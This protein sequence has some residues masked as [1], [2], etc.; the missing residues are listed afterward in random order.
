MNNDPFHYKVTPGQECLRSK[1]QI[2]KS[3]KTQG[4]LCQITTPF[5]WAHSPLPLPTLKYQEENWMNGPVSRAWALQAQGL[6]FNC[7]N[8]S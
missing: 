4:K 7:E 2:V 3:H 1:I 8:D 5:L 6:K